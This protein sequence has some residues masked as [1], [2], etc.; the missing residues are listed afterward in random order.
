MD[1]VEQKE[2]E[3]RVMALL[4]EPLLRR[5]LARP[6]AVSKGQFEDMKA[7]ICKRLAYMTPANLGALEEI[8]AANPAGKDRDRLPIGPVVL[9]YAADV[10]P[11]SDTAS[12]LMRAVFS[13]ATGLEAIQGGWSPELLGQVRR[14]RKWPGRFALTQI[15]NGADDNVRLMRRL[16]E[17]IA[18]GAALEGADQAWRDRRLAALRK[19]EEIREMGLKG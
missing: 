11:P 5:G 16:E 17:R 7:D 2:G 9:G 19:C 12:P 3:A 6:S 13:S 15:R 1:S 10:Q 4:I 14:T 18:T 8:V